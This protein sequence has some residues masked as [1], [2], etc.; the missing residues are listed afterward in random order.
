MHHADLTMNEALHDP[1]IRQ[2]LRADRVSLGDFA[3][4]LEKAARTKDQPYRHETA[5]QQA[6]GH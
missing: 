2:L 1:M 4:L 6:L 5:L 3:K